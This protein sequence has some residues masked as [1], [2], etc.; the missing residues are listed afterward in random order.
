MDPKGLIIYADGLLQTRPV[1]EYDAPGSVSN[2]V[3]EGT[4]AI[5]ATTS[6]AISRLVTE[7]CCGLVALHA[8]PTGSSEACRSQ[9]E[10]AQLLGLHGLI[11]DSAGSEKDGERVPTLPE[12]FK[13]MKAALLTDCAPVAALGKRAGFCDVRALHPS[14]EGELP[15][16]EHLVRRTLRMLGLAGGVNPIGNLFAVSQRLWCKRPRCACCYDDDDD[17]DGGGGAG[18]PSQGTQETSTPPPPPPPGAPD[19]PTPSFL[20]QSTREIASA[21]LSLAVLHLYVPAQPGVSQQPEG[22]APVQQWEAAVEASKW[23]DN[24]LA[25]LL[26]VPQVRESLL[27]TVVVGHG[28]AVDNSIGLPE[29]ETAVQPQYANL[30]PVQSYRM[31]GGRLVEDASDAAPMVVTQWLPGVTRRDAATTLSV[32]EAS[33][34]GSGGI[35]LVDHLLKEVAYKIGC[36]EKYGA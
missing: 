24:F 27:V 33:S 32:S 3:S 20:S 5:Q 9:S 26:A 36:A 12:R 10:F 23:L 6:E 8:R 15:R 19:Q 4:P 18:G 25:A 1:G 35:I 30:R 7:G 13:G 31:S 29:P 16:V 14:A 21:N 17:D 11:S 28:G 2:E 22:G 34:R